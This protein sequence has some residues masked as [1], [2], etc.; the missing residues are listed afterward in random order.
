MSGFMRKRLDSS[1]KEAYD[2]AVLKFVLA[3]G[4]P[5]EMVAGVGFQ[6]L[7]AETLVVNI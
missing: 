7:C 3:D 5:F 2:L 6:N 1:K 4:R